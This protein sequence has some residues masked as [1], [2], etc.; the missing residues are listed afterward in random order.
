MTLK[1]R[2]VIGPGG[3]G[4]IAAELNGEQIWE[5]VRFVRWSLE[6][7]DFRF[8][9]WVSGD[10]FENLS[11]LLSVFAFS[12]DSFESLVAKGADTLSEFWHYLNQ[13]DGQVREVAEGVL[14]NKNLKLLTPPA[15][16]DLLSVL[17]KSSGSVFGLS[18]PHRDIATQAIVE[19]FETIQSHREFIEVLKRIGNESEKGSLQDLMSNYYQLF[20]RRLFQSPQAERVEN[21]LASIV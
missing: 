4:G 19:I 2:L 12:E 11:R 10:A 1:G 8:L 20:P 9:D 15:K 14:R 7:S 3:G 17:S 5:L 16:A 6:T 18:D 13:T 21:W